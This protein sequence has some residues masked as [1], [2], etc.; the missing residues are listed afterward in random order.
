M[1]VIL[2]IATIVWFISPFGRQQ[3]VILSCPTR[4]GR[5][6]LIKNQASQLA[7][8]IHF[9]V[10]CPILVYLPLL[11]FSVVLSFVCWKELRDK[12][13]SRTTSKR[14]KKRYQYS[15]L[16]TWPLRPPWIAHSSWPVNYKSLKCL[17]FFFSYFFFFFF[18]CCPIWFLV[19]MKPDSDANTHRS[20]ILNVYINVYPILKLFGE[21]MKS[22]VTGYGHSSCH[23]AAT[24]MST[25]PSLVDWSCYYF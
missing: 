25:A 12:V 7:R 18:L 17:S 23:T 20:C 3:L 14:N 13:S 8:F 22:T 9:P 16:M 5:G 19:D 4:K 24:N 11:L 21:R 6:W 15:A 10:V 2:F 1:R